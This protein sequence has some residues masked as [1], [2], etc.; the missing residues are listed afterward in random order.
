MERPGNNKEDSALQSAMPFYY[1]SL[2][3]PYCAARHT[4]RE[5]FLNSFDWFESQKCYVE[6]MKNTYESLFGDKSLT[7]CRLLQD[8]IVV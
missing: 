6:N 5:N 7:Q 8:K 3:A 1:G 4:Y 2:T